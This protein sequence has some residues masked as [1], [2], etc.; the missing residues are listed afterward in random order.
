MPDELRLDVPETVRRDERFVPRVEGL[1]PGERVELTAETSDEAGRWA[2]QATFEADDGVVDLAETAPVEGNYEGVDPTGLLWSMERDDGANR[3]VDGWDPLGSHDVRVTATPANGSS[4]AADRTATATVTV[5][6]ADPGVT[7]HEAGSAAD[8]AP[9]GAWFEPPG[10]GPHPPVLVL[11]GS[12]GRVLEGIAALFASEGFA[13]FALQYLG[14]GDLP[15]RPVSV[16]LSDVDA[17]VDWFLARSTVAADDGYG[18][19]GVSMGAQLAFVLASRDD[20]VA[21]LVSDS[22]NHVCFE[23][24]AGGAWRED[25]TDLPR[26]GIPDAPPDA[27]DRPVVDAHD[28]AVDRSDMWLG[29]LAAEST[30]TRRAATLPVEESDAPLLLL[31]GSDDAQWPS[32]TFHETLLARLDAL[33]YDP[34]CEHLRYQGAGHG[35]GAP[36]TP[37]TWRPARDDQFLASGGD[38]AAH[39]RARRDAWPQVVEWFETALR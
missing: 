2:S 36:G 28:E 4:A 9:F 35:I 31:S 16:P 13:A 7:R 24:G 14:A 5:R 11:H 38:P 32:E 26:I 30:E 18:A 23:S 12:G 1:T 39:A 19:Y 17:A 22:G 10:D 15:E 3:R 33:R 25:G 34:P 21:A 20:R 29:M 6:H 37:T 27:W 8:E